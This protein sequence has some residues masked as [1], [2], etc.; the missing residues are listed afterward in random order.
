MDSWRE[1]AGRPAARTGLPAAAA[2][3]VASLLNQQSLVGLV[4]LAAWL[5]WGVYCVPSSRRP[6]G[7]LIAKA[8]WGATAGLA[9]LL[10]ALQATLQLA[11]ALG[12][13]GLHTRAVAKALDLLGFGEADTW[14]EF[15]L[16]SWRWRGRTRC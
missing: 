2:C 15:L 7:P 16:V 12:T 13:P 5:A 14:P 3:V 4:F 8:L 10:L 11:F 1:G 9:T 6:Q